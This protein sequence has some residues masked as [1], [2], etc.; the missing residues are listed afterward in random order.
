M[1][2]ERFKVGV[3]SADAGTL[4][5]KI[6]RC[7]RQALANRQSLTLAVSGLSNA[8]DLPLGLDFAELIQAAG[9]AAGADLA[10][11]GPR[12]GRADV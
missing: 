7:D 11:R 3:W 10:G 2:C 5:A 12:L 4:V 6:G 9:A 8:D 1:I